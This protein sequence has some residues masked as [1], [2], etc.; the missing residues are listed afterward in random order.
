MHTV[1]CNAKGPTK[2]KRCRAQTDVDLVAELTRLQFCNLYDSGDHTDNQDD[3]E[4]NQEDGEGNDTSM[5]HAHDS[6]NGM[7]VY[8]LCGGKRTIKLPR[9]PPLPRGWAVR[10]AQINTQK[11]PAQLLLLLE[12][13][14]KNKASK[15][16]QKKNPELLRELN[17]LGPELDDAKIKSHFSSLQQAWKVSE[18]GMQTEL[19]AIKAKV[20][21]VARSMA[22][23]HF[24]A[25]VCTGAAMH[26]GDAGVEG[27][28]EWAD[29]VS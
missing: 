28:E 11:T 27:G 13:F 4:G 6:A 2:R 10:P 20:L 26:A 9:P 12:E 25:S 14:L 17:T 29:G 19:L 16:E 21:Q 1:H 24:A 18:D 3:G 7:D 8:V 23:Q 5:H 22:E 15:C